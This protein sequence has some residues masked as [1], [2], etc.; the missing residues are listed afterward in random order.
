MFGEYTLRVARALTTLLILL[1]VFVGVKSLAAIKQFRFIGSGTTATNTIS[2]SGEGEAFMVPDIAQITATIEKDAK[3]A[4]EAQAT[5]SSQEKALLTF[6][7]GAGIADK[8]IK[9]TNFSSYPKYEWQEGTV[10]CLAIGCPPSRPG[11][12][13][14]TGYTVNETI[15]IKVRDTDKAGDIVDGI[16]KAGINQVSGPEYTV[17][18]ET[19]IEGQARDKAIADAKAKAETLAKSLGVKLV[20]IVNF[21]EG[22]GGYPV[23]MYAKAEMAF[24][25]AAGNSAPTLPKGENK[26][27][28]NVTITYEIR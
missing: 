22:G 28:S 15:T 8:D 5:V 26:Y 7:K 17:D 20:R 19:A 1:A 12:N 16:T 9:T 25:S 13:V 2:V 6:L 4:K 24:D 11:K 18:D 14:L 3:T 23:P 27:T 21:S 10:A